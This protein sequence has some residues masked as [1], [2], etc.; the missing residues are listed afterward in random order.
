[1]KKVYAMIVFYLVLFPGV[2]NAGML[3]IGARTFSSGPGVILIVLTFLGLGSYLLSSFMA[4]V[5]QG[6]IAGFIRVGG[7][8]GCLIT[9]ATQAYETIKAV[10]NALGIGL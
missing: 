9:I 6:Q 4:S 5:G 7:L 10:A 8:L 2:A 1:M 3:E